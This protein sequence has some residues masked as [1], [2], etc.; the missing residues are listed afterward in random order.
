MDVVKGPDNTPRSLTKP[1]STASD[2]DGRKEETIS[3]LI[4]AYE[5][6]LLRLCCMYLKDVSLAEDAVQETF[7]KAYRH[8]NDFR[9]D[10]SARTWLVRIA[11]NVC[12][13]ITRTA[14]F[15][16]ARNAIEF[17]SLQ[18]AQPEG[19]HEVRSTLVAEVMKLPRA[20]REVI[21]L[22][23]Y[24]G[25]NQSEIAQALHVSRMTVHRRLEKAYGLLKHVLKG[26]S[27]NEV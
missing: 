6:D 12:K 25:F 27:L 8:L 7:L 11:I 13:D 26:G 5:K 23:Y 1:I 21:L 15:R 19:Y 20:C 4:H 18:I 2:G 10:S 16:M 17:D 24:E 9:G 3:Q 14:W 22:H